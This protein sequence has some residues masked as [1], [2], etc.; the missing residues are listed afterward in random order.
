[1]IEVYFDGGTALSCICI[2][3]T[4]ID[5][6]FVKK[7][8]KGRTNNELEYLALIEAINYALKV[9]GEHKTVRFCG[10]SELIIKQM[11]HEYRVKNKYLRRFYFRA[12][13]M[14]E[15]FRVKDIRIEF[16][17]MGRN[18]NHAGVILEALLK[19]FGKRTVRRIATRSEYYDLFKL[20]E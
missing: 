15:P 18:A 7:F 2:Y 11:N 5:K 13:E 12:L 1:M 17:W 10:D 6:H 3:D 14:L 8:S 4:A 9:E 20:P 19:K 16:V